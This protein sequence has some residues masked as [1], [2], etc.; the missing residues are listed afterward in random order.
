MKKPCFLLM[1]FLQIFLLLIT[2]R[3]SQAAYLKN[4]P[5]SLKQ[6]DGA[7][8]HCYATGDEYYNWLHDADN[9]TIMRNPHTGYYVYAVLINGE[10]KPS[11]YIAGR[12]NPVRA[13]LTKGVNISPAKM[14]LIRSSELKKIPEKPVRNSLKSLKSLNQGNMNN[15]VIFIRFSDEAEFTQDTSIYSGMFNNNPGNVSMRNYF[16]EVSYDSLHVSTDFYPVSVS[17]TVLSYQDILPRSYF[18]PYDSLSNTGGYQPNERKNRED[19]LLLRAVNA[20]KNQIPVSLNLDYDNDDYV[21]NICF[22]VSGATT[23]WSTLLWPH[24]SSLY[25]QDVYI[26]NKRVWSFNFQLNDYL[27]NNAGVGVLCHEMF[28]SLGAPDLYHY[29]YDGIS[30]AGPWDLMEN[31][32]LVP[33]S[34]C[35]FMKHKY[36]FWIDSIPLIRTSGTYTLHPVTS[37]ANN[38]Y[39]IQLSNTPDEYFVVEYRKK[40]GLFES[41]LPGS[42]LLIYR[43]NTMCGNGNADGPPD[44]VY[45]FRPGGSPSGNGVINNANFS[46]NVGRPS[47]NGTTDPYPF[48]SDGTPTSINIFNISSAGNTI[49]FSVS[50]IEAPFASSDSATDITSS[51]ARIY[52]TVNPKGFSTTVSF[53]YGL[54]AAYGNTVTPVQSPLNGNS[55]QVVNVDL[56]GLA[57]GSQYHFRVKAESQEGTT[58]STDFIFNTECMLQSLPV[59]QGFNS[60]FIPV[61]W[62]KELVIDPLTPGAHN[63]AADISFVQVSASPD[64]NSAFEGSHFVKFNSMDASDGAI[65]RLVSSPFSTT[66]RQ[67]I[68]VSFEWY[69]TSDGLGQYNSEGVVLQWSA[70]GSHWN[71]LDTFLR[72]DTISGWAHKIRVLPASAENQQ[73]VLIGFY[74]ISQYGYNCY[75]DNVMIYDSLPAANFMTN[76]PVVYQFDNVSFTDLSVPNI[77]SWSWIF[78]GA[79]PDTS[80]L[81]NPSDIVYRNTGTF[82]VKLIV[83]NAYGTDTIIKD[84]FITVKSVVD[85]GPDKNIVCF[86][87]TLL[88]AQMYN[89]IGSSLLRFRWY[90]PAGLSDTTVRN[91][92]ASPPG[93]MTYIVTAIDTNFTATDTIKVNVVPLA[94]NA[95]PDVS[96]NCQDSTQLSVVTNHPTGNFLKI[97]TPEMIYYNIGLASFGPDILS[98]YV[99]KN[100]LYISSNDGCTSFP[101]DTFRNKIAVIDRAVCNFSLKALNAQ[102]AGAKGVIIVNNQPGNNVMQMGA[103][104]YGDQVHIPV[105]MVGNNDGLQIK[106][107]LLSDTVN[108]SIGYDGPALSYIWTPAA[109]LNDPASVHPIAKPLTTTT[110]TVAVSDGVCSSSSSV[111]VMINDPSVFLGNDTVF[112]HGAR[113]VLNAHNPGSAYLWNDSS[114]DSVLIVSTSD[115]C[116]VRVNHPNGCYAT[117][118]ILITEL[119]IPDIADS[120]AGS[121]N[122]CQAADQVGYT[123]PLINNASSY[124]WTLAPVI[125]GTFV[126]NNNFITIN[127]DDNYSGVALLT[128]FG[129]NM[130]GNGNACRKRITVMPIPS[131]PQITLNGSALESSSSDGNQWYLDSDVIPGATSRQYTPAQSG[132]YHVVVMGANGCASFPSNTINFQLGISEKSGN[133][134]VKLYPNPAEESFVVELK[135]KLTGEEFRCSVYNMNGQELKSVRFKT[136]KTEINIKD[137]NKG[138]YFVRISG[139]KESAVLKLIK[140]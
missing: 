66:G 40:T 8:L 35:A 72:T 39:K 76:N 29:S 4:V 31:E 30:P 120:I 118:T 87:S 56:S 63:D 77:T 112:C 65:M 48:L 28:H 36:G 60:S 67:H 33:Q 53:E 24:K 113:I 133:S 111:T 13:G 78:T 73:K 81:Q 137:L 21:D 127:W 22:I 47:F 44:E 42:G 126:I 123:T 90:P 125:A 124:E 132:N 117:D 52:G 75:M 58:Y 57:P 15:L 11:V 130:C 49:S 138:V 115:T 26:R 107:M 41:S 108:A 19:S 136:N 23:A 104:S 95:G 17:S 93:N 20:V 74:F 25:T 62:N 129:N 92:I 102:I 101:T 16:K 128:V 45:F 134:K 50:G 100:T 110:Y 9:F 94:V 68:N 64:L 43:I 7:V 59:V 12:D 3:T 139:S 46:S 38:A 1:L 71:E 6:P 83:A 69:N 79:L 70:D 140:Q 103:G 85:A 88:N 80:T 55:A 99:N 18:Q 135:E 116:F 82:P 89:N 61:C 37:S 51:F 14:L 91:P 97:N 114:T 34:M 54:T 105:I 86:G 96:I 32:G 131:A 119:N 10:L 27:L 121:I 5:V 98:T 122:V 84:H 106:N 109:G 2:Y